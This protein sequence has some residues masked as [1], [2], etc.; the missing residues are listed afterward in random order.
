MWV[1]RIMGMF[2]RSE[3]VVEEHVMAHEADK[4]RRKRQE[5]RELLARE[6]R[7]MERLADIE[8]RIYTQ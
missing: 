4:M 2:R 5:E 6:Q 8:R 1:E 7:V 3:P